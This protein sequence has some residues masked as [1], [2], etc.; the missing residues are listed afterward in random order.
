MSE[1]Y[2]TPQR[3]S[4]DEPC[5]HHWLIVITMDPIHGDSSTLRCDTCGATEP[6]PLWGNFEHLPVYGV[7][8]FEPSPTK[9]D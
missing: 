7:S 5:H 3:Y 1:P 4:K 8:V 2:D 6:F 9:T